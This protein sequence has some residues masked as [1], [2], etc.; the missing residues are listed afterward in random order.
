MTRVV[1]GFA[2]GALC[3]GFFGANLRRDLLVEVRALRGERDLVVAVAEAAT[4]VG[5][6][7]T[8]YARA[9]QYVAR[10]LARN[11]QHDQA[12]MGGE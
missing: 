8:D 7:C 3:A 9:C 2:L 6:A 12:W 5:D 1:L 10:E 11:S 4:K